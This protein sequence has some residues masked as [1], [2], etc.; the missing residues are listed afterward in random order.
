MWVNEGTPTMSFVSYTINVEYLF[1]AS[2]VTWKNRQ[3]RRY[4]AIFFRKYKTYQKINIL[5]SRFNSSGTSFFHFSQ[6][7]GGYFV[8][9]S[10]EV[11]QT[12]ENFSGF[13]FVSIL[14]NSVGLPSCRVI[15]PSDRCYAPDIHTCGRSMHM[16]RPWNCHY[17]FYRIKC[18][19]TWPS[20]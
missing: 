12:T 2:H 14:Y 5:G 17:F 18:P 11:F 4:H 9:N 19:L 3:Y 16:F 13:R 10:W 15:E 1:S 20:A 8:I 6:N 7:N